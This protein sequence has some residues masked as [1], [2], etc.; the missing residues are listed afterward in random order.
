MIVG[1][2]F[3]ALLVIALVSI[4]KVEAHGRWKCPGPRD[5]LDE[6]GKHITFDNTGN[7]YA[8]CGPE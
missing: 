3:L 6:S 1:T 8:A 4:V 2:V 7:K 5:A